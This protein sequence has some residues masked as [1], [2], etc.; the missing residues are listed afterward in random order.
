[1]RGLDFILDLLFP[2]RCAVCRNPSDHSGLCGE[3]RNRY[4]RELFEKCPECGKDPSECVCGSEFLVHT[5][6]EIGGKKCCALCWYKSRT[7][8]PDEDRVTERMIWELKNHG[9]FAE[10]FAGELCRC[11]K[12]LFE[13]GNLSFDGW[14]LAYIPRS[15]EKFAECGVDQSREIG[16]RLAKKLEIPFAELFEREEGREQKHLNAAERLENAENSLRIREDRLIPGGKYLLLDDIITSG[17]TME[18]AAKL[19]YF[20]GAGAVYPIATAR[21]M[22]KSRH[23]TNHNCENNIKETML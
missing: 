12:N 8:Y 20:H 6:T 13:R 17:A 7:N 15:A 10:F 5:R 22:P 16:R 2:P 23:H 18:T 1:M 3:C 21:N 14:M 4:L 19:L 11:M 9:M